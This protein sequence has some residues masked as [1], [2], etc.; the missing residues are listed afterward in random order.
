MNVSQL[1]YTRAVAETLSFSR[2][3]E[4][5]FVTQPGLSNAIGQL[6]TELGGRLF[7][8]NTKSVALTTFGERMLPYVVAVLDQL[9]ELTGAAK[10]MSEASNRVLRIGFC[11]LLDTDLLNSVLAPFM[12]ENPETEFVLRESYIE[13]LAGKLSDE[14]LDVVI[15]PSETKIRKSLRLRFYSDELMYFPSSQDK[16]SNAKTVGVVDIAKE[17]FTIAGEGC[18]LVA[19][20]RQL[21]DSEG[22]SFETYPG[23]AISY[24]ILEE[25]AQLG[26]GPT[27]LPSTK[28]SG[29]ADSALKLV[30]SSGKP[31]IISFD[32]FYG[33]KNRNGKNVSK[34]IRYFENTVPNYV[35]GLR[36][37]G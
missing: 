5:C 19:S 26:I 10:E 24:S 25:W 17:S 7:E 2:A 1:K 31:A 16:R 18:G 34:L 14:K 11:P 6:E 36:R 30:D 4:Q 23:Q 9:E 8:R 20:L 35:K 32:I 29:I 12:K 15:A 3:S 13:D 33:A 21:F 27:I 37:I 28:T 22:F